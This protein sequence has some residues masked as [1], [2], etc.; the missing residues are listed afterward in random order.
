MRRILTPCAL[1]L[2]C[3]SDF[4]PGRANRADPNDAGEGDDRLPVLRG[5]R[6][7]DAAGGGG[8]YGGPVI[9]QRAPGGGYGERNDQCGSCTSGTTFFYFF[10]KKIRTSGMIKPS[11]G[12]LNSFF[13][14]VLL[15][16]FVI[17][18]DEVT[19]VDR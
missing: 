14:Y 2:D 1:P 9:L 3:C 6:A 4:G 15:H 12:M 8:V 19:S 18:R 11:W 10:L 5:W 7:E 13:L 16:F 17:G